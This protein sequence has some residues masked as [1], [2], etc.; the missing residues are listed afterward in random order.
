[1]DDVHGV[2]LQSQTHPSAAQASRASMG[3]AQLLPE[4]LS[5]RLV[6]FED[7]FTPLPAPNALI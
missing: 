7:G 6:A 1:M 5:L 3:T 4:L 2:Q